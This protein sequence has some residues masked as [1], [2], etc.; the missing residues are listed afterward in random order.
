M[1]A[2]LFCRGRI[3]QKFWLIGYKV[4]YTIKRESLFVV[5]E[6]KHYESIERR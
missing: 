3:I 1:A 5:L 6:L 4:L 2:V